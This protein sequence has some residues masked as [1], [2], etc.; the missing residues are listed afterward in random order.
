MSKLSSSEKIGIVFVVLS[1]VAIVLN[2]FEIEQEISKYG[3][4]L[5]AMGAVFWYL[6]WAKR[7]KATKKIE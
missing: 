2:T 7:K 5:A 1:L 6:G 3:S 4:Y